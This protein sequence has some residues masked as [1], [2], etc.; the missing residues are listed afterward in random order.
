MK[1]LESLVVSVAILAGLMVAAGYAD[2]GDSLKSPAEIK[3]KSRTFSPEPGISAKLKVKIENSRD[4]PVQAIVQLWTMPTPADRRKLSEAG[5]QLK[6]FLG[7]T[8]YLALCSQTAYIDVVRPLL[9]WAGL[10]EPEDKLSLDILHGTYPDWAIADD[11]A[12]RLLVYIP[13]YVDR[14]KAEATV[15]SHAVRYSPYGH[16][17]QWAVET[18]VERIRDLA[19]EE[20]VERIELGPPPK[21]LL[22]VGTDMRG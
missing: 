16:G 2:V 15:K 18:V 20:A 10:L 4:L 9:R 11:G 17:N 22:G 13:S 8:A 1:G 6:Q 12:I 21:G 14:A 5:V 19:G 3:L 7:G